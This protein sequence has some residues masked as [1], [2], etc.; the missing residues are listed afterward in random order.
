MAHGFCPLQQHCLHRCSPDIGLPSALTPLHQHPHTV[1]LPPPPSHSRPPTLTAQPS[2]PQVWPALLDKCPREAM[3]TEAFLAQAYTRVTNR[4]RLKKKERANEGP[5]GATPRG[6]G[7]LA[8]L[9][10]G[11][12]PSPRQ[13]LADEDLVPRARGRPSDASGFGREA[14]AP[15]STQAEAGTAGMAGPDED[16][17]RR[18]R[19]VVFGADEAE[20]QRLAKQKV[21]GGLGGWGGWGWGLGRVGMVGVGRVGMVGVGMV[22]EGGD[23][24]CGE[25]GD[26][27]C[28][29]GW[30]RFGSGEGD[31]VG[32][33]CSLLCSSHLP[34]PRSARGIARAPSPTSFR[35]GLRA[36]SS[37]TSQQLSSPTRVRRTRQRS[38][39]EC[40]RTWAIS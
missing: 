2:P 4:L 11:P 15:A 34:A 6:Q 24:W 7:A 33:H 20:A 22:G 38:A 35:A 14:P 23:G 18:D 36:A 27:G 10:A 12:G 5:G 13:S 16:L 29:D 21:R 26:S 17:L 32:W 28:G 30:G 40:P 19:A 25:G 1:A 31:G 9:T 39:S 8:S 37:R 3:L